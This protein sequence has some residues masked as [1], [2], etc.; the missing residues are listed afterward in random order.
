MKLF[1]L[2]IL[3]LL[4]FSAFTQNLSTDPTTATSTST[5][6]VVTTPP[7]DTTSASPTATE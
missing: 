5:S 6:T 1:H 2:L 3:A 7:T 4:G